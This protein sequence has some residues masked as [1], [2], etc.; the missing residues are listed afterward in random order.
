MLAS[1]IGYMPVLELLLKNPEIDINRKDEETGCNS[2]WL[3]SMYG[4]G[5]AMNYLASKGI[6]ILNKHKETESNALHCA[7]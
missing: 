2:F 5:A 4:K 7:I 3:A 6:D 1:V